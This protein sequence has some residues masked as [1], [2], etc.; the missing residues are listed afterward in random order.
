M[1]MR[2]QSIFKIDKKKYFGD[3]LFAFDIDSNIY[4]IDDFEKIY[5][6]F[7]GASVSCGLFGI[8]D[9]FIEKYQ[10]LDS[11]FVKNKSSTFFFDATGHSMEPTIFPGEILVVDRSVEATNG[12]VCIVCFEDNLI[13]KRVFFKKNHILLCSDNPTFKP[14]QINDSHSVLVWGVVI[15]RA[16]D[17]H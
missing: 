5:L 15:A 17:I 7:F 6:P 8:T 11:R 14:I 12:K 13:C 10:S 1:G 16:G 3:S 9:D 2:R 4:P